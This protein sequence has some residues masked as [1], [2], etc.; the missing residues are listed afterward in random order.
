MFMDDVENDLAVQEVANPDTS[1][2]ESAPT[3]EAQAEDRQEKNWREMRR[4]NAELERK[5]KVQEEL[6]ERLIKNQ[7]P[8]QAQQEPVDEI[9]SIPDGD[10]LPKGQV[11]KMMEREAKKAEKRAEDAVNRILEEREKAN[12]HIKLKNKFADFDEVVTAETLEMLE[13]QDPEL[14]V[15][16]ADLK[17]PY[18]MGFQTYKYIKSMGLTEKAPTHRR[19]KEVEKKLDQ[20]QKTV[21]SPQAFDKRPMAQT[22]QMTE[23]QKQELWKEMNSYA[24]AADGVPKL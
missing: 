9:D 3:Q 8:S 13:Q 18:K 16:I 7:V 4:I 20:N 23:K 10:Y 21:Q 14:A 5:A 2:Q 6:L 12:F 24:Q 17:D 22:F 1:P 15:T 11:K 19:V